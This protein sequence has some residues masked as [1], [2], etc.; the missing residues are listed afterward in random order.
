M[1]D[2]KWCTDPTDYSRTKQGFFPRNPCSIN[3]WMQTNLVGLLQEKKDPSNIILGV[4]LLLVIFMLGT[5]QYF[6]ERAAGNVA[7][8]LRSLLPSN[9]NVIRDGKEFSLA[10]PE[11][12][13]GDIVHMTLGSRVAADIKVIQSKDLKLDFSSLTGE[14]DPIA[15]GVTAADEKA[16]ESKNI[17][18]MS[19]QVWPLYI[20]C[21]GVSCMYV[22]GV[23]G[24]YKR[25][26]KVVQLFSSTFR[27]AAP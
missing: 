5:T 15:M 11:L 7:A 14:S 17:A 9:A 21:T 18:F 25:P 8:Q 20:T 16:H 2:V 23:R 27:S 24:L 1:C 26:I 10:A 12:V 4:V 3:S 6:N 13:T 19:S 22:Y